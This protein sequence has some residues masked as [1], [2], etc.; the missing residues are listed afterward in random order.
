MTERQ[1]I[2]TVIL[3]LLCIKPLLALW[4]VHNGGSF[5]FWCAGVC[6]VIWPG[7]VVRED[8]DSGS[9]GACETGGAASSGSE[10][11][12]VKSGGFGG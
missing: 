11:V 2:Y 9:N 5:G 3:L 7:L 8:L 6:V 1:E 12:L 4:M 10:G